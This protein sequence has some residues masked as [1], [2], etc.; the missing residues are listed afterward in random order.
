M[1]Y[2]FVIPVF[3][4]IIMIIHREYSSKIM[5]KNK[6]VWNGKERRSNVRMAK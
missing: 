1:W 6:P 5:D 4:Y 3:L 2:L